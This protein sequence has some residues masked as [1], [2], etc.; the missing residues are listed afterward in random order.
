LTLNANSYLELAGC[1][2]TLRELTITNHYY[3][4]GIYSAAQLAPLVSDSSGG[5]GRVIVRGFST[6]FVIR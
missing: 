1:A 4:P 5:N 3:R 2:L 6:V